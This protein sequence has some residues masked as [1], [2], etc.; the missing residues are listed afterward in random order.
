MFQLVTCRGEIKKKFCIYEEKIDL[1][2]NKLLKYH[3][4]I[5]FHVCR[6]L[7]Q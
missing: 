7:Y 4:I 3:E 1:P 2:E 6:E 5:K